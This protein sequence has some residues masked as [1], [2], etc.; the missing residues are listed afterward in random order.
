[1][2]PPDDEAPAKVLTVI[3]R[4]ELAVGFLMS[5]LSVRD[6]PTTRLLRISFLSPDPDL[7][8]NIVNEVGLQYILSYVEANRDLV[9]EV[10]EWLDERLAELKGSLD[11]SERRLLEFKSENG[12]VGVDGDVGRLGEQELL[13]GAADL[14]EARLRLSGVTNRLEE[15]SGETTLQG[16]L[17]RL[18]SDALVQQTRADIRR[19]SQEIQRLSTQYGPRHPLRL[20]RNSELDAL[21]ATPRPGGRS[22]ARFAG[23]RARTA[24]EGGRLAR[25]APGSQP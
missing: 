4:Q 24:V 17:A 23:E 3:E 15:L 18:Q 14:A 2:P 7:S 16:R 6:V 12:L 25:G 1:M 19:V 9:G 13:Q 11:E 22:S 10:S 5:G 21:Q 20:E 8:A